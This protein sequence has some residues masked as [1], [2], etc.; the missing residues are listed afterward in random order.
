MKKFK[1]LKINL[2]KTNYDEKQII[3][4]KE[5]FFETVLNGSLFDE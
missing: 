3:E 2:K 5:K 4:N 1:K